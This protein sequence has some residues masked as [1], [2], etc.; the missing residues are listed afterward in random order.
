MTSHSGNSVGWTV[1]NS[2]STLLTPNLSL[3]H[4]L[5]T[6][7]INSVGESPL[8]LL[9]MAE[10]GPPRALNSETGSKMGEE[11]YSCIVGTQGLYMLHWC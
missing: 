11:S 4:S 5:K 10:P 2:F 6:S 9:R 8:V 7:G 1:L 3:K